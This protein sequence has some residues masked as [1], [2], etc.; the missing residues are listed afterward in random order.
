MTVRP[1]LETEWQSGWH[2]CMGTP[3]QTV[4]KRAFTLRIQSDP[5]NSPLSWRCPLHPSQRG[6]EAGGGG[7]RPSEVSHSQVKGARFEIGLSDSRPRRLSTALNFTAFHSARREGKCFSNRGTPE[8]RLR[9]FQVWK[10]NGHHTVDWRRWD[11]SWKQSPTRIRLE[12]DAQLVAFPWT[13]CLALAP[14]PD[15][16]PFMQKRMEFSFDYVW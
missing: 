10:S 13:C 11:V 5:Q 12:L 1:C 7:G 6:S 16:V 14:N 3:C 8:K 9:Y 15:S 2:H 4:V